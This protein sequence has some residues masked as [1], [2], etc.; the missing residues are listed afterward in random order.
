MNRPIT[1]LVACATLGL[2]STAAAAAPGALPT[3]SKTLSGKRGACA[4]STYRAPMAGYVSARLAGASTSDWD[5]VAVDRASRRH[6]AASR[7]FGSNEVVQSWT[8]AGQRIAFVACHRSGAARSVAL[9]IAF[10]DVKPPKPGGTVSVVRVHASSAQLDGL[11]R[12]GLDVT[13]SRGPGWADVLVA[14]PKQL[15]LLDR[16]G[17]AHRTRIADLDAYGRRSDRA[18]AR[19]TARLGA[20]GSPL[21]SARSTYREYEDVQADLKALVEK[22][23]DT[24]RPVVVGKTFQGRDIQGVEIAKDVNVEDG[25]PVFF[26]MGEHHAREWPSEEIAMEYAMLLASPGNDAR[27]LDLLAR[28]RTVIVPIV[29]A[30]GFVSTRTDAPVDP[31]DNVLAGNDEDF[32]S[33]SPISGDTAESVAPPGGILAYRRKNCDGEF[34]DGNFPC[35]LQYGVD[36]NRNYGNLW[37]G[38]G[39]SQDP[40]SQSFHGPAPR[41]EPETQAVWNYARTHQ[42]TGLISLHTIA[43]LVLRP[44]GE[45]TAG[46]A[47][48]E[49]AMKD[50][51]DRMADE[52]GYTSEYGFQLYDTAGTTEDDTYAATG[53]YGYTIEIGPAGGTFHMPYETAVVQQWEKGDK[54]GK[55]G[56]REALLLMG[57]VVADTRHH[58]VIAGH[59]PAG[60]K[61]TL[62]RSFETLT[63]PYCDIGVD[64]VVTV[65]T[66][67]DQL[68]CPGGIKDPQKLKD[69]V[70]TSTTV[71]ASGSYEWHVNQSTR[72]FVGGGAVIRKLNEKPTREVKFTGNPADPDHAPGNSYEDREF[73]IGAGEHP[74]SVKIHVEW[75][76][77]EDYDLEVYRKNADGS[78]PDKPIATSGHNPGT[79][80]EVVLQGDQISAA[81]YVVRVVNFAAVSG[82]WTATV[83]LYDTTETVTTGHPE[84][85]TMTCAVNGAVVQTRQVY[86]AR[87]ER[88]DLDACSPDAPAVVH[89]GADGSAQP[90]VPGTAGSSVAKRP[91][92]AKKVTR[93]QVR[94]AQRACAKAKRAARQKH[95]KAKGL[96]EH[97][98]KRTCAK[99]AKL[100]KQ[101]RRGH[102]KH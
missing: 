13:E 91:H 93:A 12:L 89:P 28:E 10:A 38:P 52:T 17:L 4:T 37:G 24:V 43:A 39:S 7:S 56:L 100:A 82:T 32:N 85:Y 5:L 63:S 71:P 41:S 94:K 16:T 102:A 72:P 36:N 8:T 69:S 19:Y 64:P 48:D 65:A 35:D 62:S 96:A 51:G 21:P 83:G 54:T 87:G 50:L 57:D 46:L 97:R 78:I 9:T 74:S 98:A 61:L 58:A 88:L 3:I 22:H 25:R 90:G 26:L 44:P 1:V 49:K 15:S 95:G 70:V 6:I 31:Y 80:E 23:P 20:A 40:T 42:V 60:A 11:E 29:N 18:D 55:H 45:H 99:A 76:T 79:P 34:P 73:T 101:Y 75:G 66:V 30:D 14:G 84:P 47:P 2:A 67:P 92:G 27:V 86:I 59:A 77:P 33:V 81:T 53:G 68:A